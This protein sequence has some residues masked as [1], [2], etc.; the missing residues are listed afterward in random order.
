M[1]HI[2]APESS[3]IALH[4]HKTK[5]HT[6]HTNTRTH[7]RS[8]THTRTHTPFPLFTHSHARTHAH[9][10]TFSLSGGHTRLYGHIWKYGHISENSQEFH[11]FSLLPVCLLHALSYRALSYHC[12]SRLD[13]DNI[14][15]SNSAT[16]MLAFAPCCLHFHHLQ[17]CLCH[18]DF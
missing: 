2:L 10:H 1:P 7:T 11:T 3:A 17:H 13:A 4:T 18:N 5:I 15:S 8:R 6:R 14:R 16:R 12:R 9:A